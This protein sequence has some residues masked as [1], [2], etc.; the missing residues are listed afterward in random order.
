MWSRTCSAGTS[1]IA[2]LTA[3]VWLAVAPAR[4][5]A[6]QPVESRDA[7]YRP[8]AASAGE[9]LYREACAACHGADG[10][11]APEALVG[12]DVPLPD[13]T[14]CGFATREPDADWIAVAHQGGPVRAFDRMMPAFGD[15]LT[16]GELQRVMDYIRTL[17]DDDDWP[18][19]ELNLPRALVTEKAYPEDEAVFTTAIATE[20]PGSI[21]NE[22]VYEKRFGARNQ[23]ELSVP[24]GVRERT[25]EN[26]DWT[27]G[28]GDIGLGVKRAFFHSLASGTI[29]SGTAEVILP[30]GD[31]D[32]TFGE[33]TVIVEPFLALGQI[34]PEDAFLQLQAGVGVPLD[35]DRADDEAF[36]RAVLGRSFTEGRWGRVWSP[37]VELLA[38]RELVSGASTDWDLLPQL[39]VTLN[40]RQHVMANAGVRIPLTDAD[41]RPT[42]ILVYLLWDWFD[43]GLLEGW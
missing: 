25:P 14:D 37:M 34:L 30:T 9:R 4:A 38:D 19:G 5:A 43:G 29:L 12:F 23:F 11:G 7:S 36:G 32:D 20:G 2:A 22:V 40:T 21:E 18:R 35:R 42:E 3:S 31:E 1:A 24:F 41:V 16:V 17:C 10:T 6:Q 27:G 15:A 13:F 39:Q 8:D 33:G 26:G 28:M